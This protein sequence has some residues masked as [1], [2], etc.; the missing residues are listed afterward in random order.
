M[1]PSMRA[2]CSLSGQGRQHDVTTLPPVIREHFAFIQREV[3]PKLLWLY[4][5]GSQEC[6]C[7]HH[8]VVPCFTKILNICRV[9]PSCLIDSWLYSDKNR[10]H[11]HPPL[12]QPG[13]PVNVEG[14]EQ[15]AVTDSHH[16]LLR[17]DQ[18]LNDQWSCDPSVLGLRSDKGHLLHES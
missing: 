15:I 1:I 12:L 6:K 14:A 2:K 11:L 18:E 7:L 3:W 4:F 16:S 10:S 9:T 13:A 8:G 17:A 5:C